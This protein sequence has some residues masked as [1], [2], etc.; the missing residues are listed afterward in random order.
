MLRASCI[1]VLSCG[2]L[3]LVVA[4]WLA[5]AG[6]S[7]GVSCRGLLRAGGVGGRVSE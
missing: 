7:A 1:P 6:G 2:R 3:V 4:L 5:V